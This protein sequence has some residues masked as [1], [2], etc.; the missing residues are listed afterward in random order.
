MFRHSIRKAGR[1][2]DAGGRLLQWLARAGRPTAAADSSLQAERAEP[3]GPYAAGVWETVA[4]PE[5]QRGLGWRGWPAAGGRWGARVPRRTGPLGT[6]AGRRLLVLCDVENLT[7]GARN[8][9]YKVSYGRLGRLLARVSAGCEL[10]AFFS[11]EREDDAR[12]AY[13]GARNWMAHVHPIEVVHTVRG[14]QRLA[15]SDNL[16]LL[17]AGFLAAQ[18]GAETIVVASGDGTLVC[19]MARFLRSVAQDRQIVS[20]SLAGSTS[21][22]LNPAVNPHLSAAMHVGRDI[23][24]P[25]QPPPEPWPARAF[26]EKPTRRATAAAPMLGHNTEEDPRRCSHNGLVI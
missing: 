2:W 22:R 6:L 12:T 14:R 17:W 1:W 25:L 15:N 18:T 23:L 16:I 11:S 26:L 8:L 4:W 7:Y 13:F 24:N 10:H 20:L 21:T 5:A 3:E 19:D 9:G